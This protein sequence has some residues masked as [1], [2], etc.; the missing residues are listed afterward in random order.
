MSEKAY[1]GTELEI[2]A[3][4]LRWKEY[5]GETI[6]PFIG[7]KVLEVGAGLG[8][9]TV[10]LC[11]G[12]QSDWLCL[13][14]DPALLQ[15]IET[16]I[17][18][19]EFPP[20]CRACGGFV[21]DLRR[22]ESFDTILY[23]DVL[24]HIADDRRELE[25]ARNH[26]SIGS[27]LI[28]LSP[29]HEFLY[30]PFDK[31]IG[32]YRRYTEGSISALTPSNCR[33]IKLVQLDSLGMLTSLANRIFLRQSIPSEKQ[34]LFWDRNLVP[35]SRCLDRLANYQFGRSIICVWERVE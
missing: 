17:S 7:K 24:E 29:A 34:I 35:F 27:R 26:L 2:F 3:K 25:N 11:D 12:S 1:I 13:E 21:T 18:S 22:S 14:P 8:A 16:R 9:N 10:A 32:H 5:F 30:S 20:C 28:V 6:A 31:A 33:I 4:A 23:L 19:G 15:V